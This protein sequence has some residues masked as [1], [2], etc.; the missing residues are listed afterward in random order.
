MSTGIYVEVEKHND[1][2]WCMMKTKETTNEY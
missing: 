1:I 2:K